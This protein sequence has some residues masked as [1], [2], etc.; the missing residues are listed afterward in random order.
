MTEY[1]PVILPLVWAAI[2]AVG[3]FIYVLLDGFDLGL[4]VLFPFAPN[5]RCRDA[6][7]NSVA[8]YWDGNET[9][10]VLGGGGLLAAFPLA[11]SLLLPALYLPLILM[12][13]GLI[14]RGV[15]FEF[16]Y[17]ADTSR[18]M[19]DWAFA[20]GSTL[21]AL[22]QGGAV[23]AFIQGFEVKDNAY[24]GGPFD[25]LTPFV[26]VTAVAL[27]SGY[28][29]LACGWMIMKG[30]E[31]LRDWAYKVGRYAI[32]AVGAFI[33]IFSLWTPLMHED[34]AARWFTLGNIVML[35][36][37]P[38]LTALSVVGVWYALEQRWKHVPFLL[39]VVIFLLCYTGLAVSL[40]PFII[41]PDVTI[42]DAAAAPESQLFMLYGAI[43][44][45]PIILGYTAYS[46]YS[47]WH[48]K[49]HG[50]H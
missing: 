10:L 48:V 17:K 50:Y 8:P 47:M 29:L 16:R 41:P 43:P 15:A 31:E 36:P 20:G 39:S 22:M 33:V 24:A 4:G 32:V 40:F 30:D 3:V 34:I 19:W 11:Y 45:V 1:L 44:L 12:L 27:V 18:W 14:L 46:Y 13:A 26:L 6:M 2:L 49:D 5:H 38:I 7:M 42:W 9:W 35:S 21:A 37:V 25:W 28:V 23:G